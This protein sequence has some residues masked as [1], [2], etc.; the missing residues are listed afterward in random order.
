MCIRDSPCAAKAAIPCG[1][2]VR[3]QHKMLFAASK[4]EKLNTEKLTVDWSHYAK[5]MCIR[6]SSCNVRQRIFQRRISSLTQKEH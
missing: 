2:A 3:K 6:D 1:L 5:K 4:F